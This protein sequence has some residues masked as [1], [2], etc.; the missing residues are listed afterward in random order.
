[1]S[2]LFDCAFDMVLYQ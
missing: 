1:M 2:L